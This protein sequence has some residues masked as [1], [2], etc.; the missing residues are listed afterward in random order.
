MQHSKTKK[1]K[2]KTSYPMTQLPTSNSH[3]IS[4]RRRSLWTRDLALAFLLFLAR[5]F[6]LPTSHLSGLDCPFSLFYLHRMTIIYAELNCIWRLLCFAFSSR[7][8]YWFFLFF[9][10]HSGF[11]AL[12]LF[13]LSYSFSSFSIAT[14]PLFFFLS[15]L[16]VYAIYY[17]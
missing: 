16:L 9:S 2:K 11:I 6:H 3:R 8:D 5:V 4:S 15:P 12:V 10:D 7:L 13:F 14:Y 1:K 17:F